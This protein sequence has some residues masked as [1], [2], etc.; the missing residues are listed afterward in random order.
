MKIRYDRDFVKYWLASIISSAGSR[1]T[2]VAMPVLVFDL[3]GSPFLTGLVVAFEAMAYVLVGLLAGTVA[4]RV[5]RKRLLVGGDLVNAVALGSVPVAAALDALTVGHVF[6]VVAVSGVA[7]VFFDAANFASLPMLVGRERMAA[8]YSVLYGPLTVVG[9]VAPGLAGLLL[10]TMTPAGVLAVDAVSFLAS[11]VL[12]RAIG[13]AM[14][15]E[16]D[17]TTRRSL[18]AEAREGLVFLWN[19]PTIRPMTIMSFAQSASGGAALGQFVPVAHNLFGPARAAWSASVM[20][21]AFS[22]GGLISTVVY[23]RLRKR[24]A[25]GRVALASTPIAAILALLCGLPSSLV[26]LAVLIAAWATIYTTNASN[27]IVFRQSETPEPLLSRVNAA[28]RMLAWGVGTPAG[29]FVSGLV[30]SAWGPRWAFAVA[31]SFGVLATALA[32]LSPLRS[33]PQPAH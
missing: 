22:V 19:H 24:V 2:Y 23:P 3:T 6:V 5:D 25:A 16:R 17:A 9:I 1:L 4:D 32:W 21:L 26:P 14:S 15:R 13:R 30:A 11:A 7:T 10:A 33:Q 8:A 18:F 29:A 31:A 27:S 28:G 12:L 20:F